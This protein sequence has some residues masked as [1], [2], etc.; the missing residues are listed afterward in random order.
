MA[1]AL[2]L[3][4]RHL[5]EVRPAEHVPECLDQVRIGGA[6]GGFPRPLA[7]VV[8][9][10]IV[11]GLLQALELGEIF[12]VKDGAEE[13]AELAPRF[14]AAGFRDLRLVTQRRAQC[15]SCARE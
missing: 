5:D 11:V 6:H 15:R 10:E 2:D 13:P 4:L 3:V 7:A 12:E 8:R 9:I 1:G 14:A